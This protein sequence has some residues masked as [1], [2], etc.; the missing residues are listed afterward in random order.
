MNELATAKKNRTKGLI[1]RK[2]KNE[3]DLKNI[4]KVIS[5][6]K[7]N[8]EKE[9]KIIKESH[10]KENKIIF[11][12]AFKEGYDNTIDLNGEDNEEQIQNET[13]RIKLKNEQEMKCIEELFEKKIEKMKT[14]YEKD[15][16]VWDGSIEYYK[17]QCE[18][19]DRKE[20]QKRSRKS[21]RGYRG[22][23]QFHHNFGNY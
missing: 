6:T 20:A 16:E 2:F 14:Q 1:F 13:K 8:G 11:D 4:E 9:L 21:I 18:Q 12:N 15:I 5:E 10:D 17:Y 7:E 3:E 23:G 22:R 19:F